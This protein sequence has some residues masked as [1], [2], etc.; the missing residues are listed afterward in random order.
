MGGK[1]GPLDFGYGLAWWLVGEWDIEPDGVDQQ[2]FEAMLIARA[3]DP[4]TEET[5]GYKL[6]TERMRKHVLNGNNAAGKAV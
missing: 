6:L 3:C 4:N 2:S 5:E 1:G